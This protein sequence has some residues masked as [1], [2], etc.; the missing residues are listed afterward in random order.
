[1]ANNCSNILTISGPAEARR[2]LRNA[3]VA[4]DGSSLSPSPASSQ[5]PPS[6]H[7]N[8]L[9]KGQLTPL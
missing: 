3:A 7:V 8:R 6:H 9:G 2:S 1:M 4:D 5:P